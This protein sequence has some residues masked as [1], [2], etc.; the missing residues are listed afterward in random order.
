[1]ININENEISM[2]KNIYIEVYLYN[3]SNT[4]VLETEY[5]KILIVTL[6][7][8]STSA[9]YPVMKTHLIQISN[10]INIIDSKKNSESINTVK[11]YQIDDNIL[12]MLT[13]LNTT[14][15]TLSVCV[16]NDEIEISEMIAI[17]GI[18]N[19]Y[20]CMDLFFL[21]DLSYIM[22]FS[23]TTGNFIEICPQNF[24]LFNKISTLRIGSSRAQFC[25]FIKI[26]DSRVLLLIYV[27]SRFYFY[28]YSIT[29][30]IRPSKKY[31]NIDGVVIDTCNENSLARIFVKI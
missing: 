28:I 9:T 14:I 30:Y 29:K 22:H 13:T 27:D 25:K 4:Y 6:A 21:D 15:Y 2:F 11:F 19:S 12:Y 1:M 5:N 24:G 31:D 10:D 8:D 20:D 26:N 23:Y 3:T 18:T 7:K 17:D 16:I